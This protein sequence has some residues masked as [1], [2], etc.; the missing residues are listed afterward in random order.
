[1]LLDEFLKEHR[2]NEPQETSIAE[3]REQIEALSASLQK[4]RAEIQSSKS[5]PQT[6]LNS[7]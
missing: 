3:L 1:M 4:V 6:V 5:E 7:Q 2:K